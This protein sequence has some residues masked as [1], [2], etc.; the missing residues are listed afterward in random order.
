MRQI[1]ETLRSKP[2]YQ[3]YLISLKEIL[4]QENGVCLLI[5]DMKK[6][7]VKSSVE[8]VG[9]SKV[10]S[11]CAVY[12]P[13]LSSLCY[14]TKWAFGAPMQTKHNTAQGVALYYYYNVNAC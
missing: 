11:G 4:N 10:M 13:P 3:V 2:N 12:S 6:E 9:T 5:D 8:P 14:F 1:D 7:L